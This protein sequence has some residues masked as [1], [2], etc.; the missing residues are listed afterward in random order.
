MNPGNPAS[1]TYSLYRP[2]WSVKVFNLQEN[3]AEAALKKSGPIVDAF[4][5]E[6]SYMKGI[7]ITLQDEWPRYSRARPFMFR[8][9]TPGYQLP[10]SRAV[11]NEDTVRFYQRG[12]GTD[13]PLIQFLSFY[14]VLEYHFLRVT[15]ELLYAK[16]TRRMNDPRF[17]ATSSSLDRIIQ[18]VV[19]HKRGTDE[20]E[21]LK[22]VLTKYVDE[23][24]LME[25]LRSYEVYLVKPF[26]SKKR[27]L[28]A[29]GSLILG[30]VFKN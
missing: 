2:L 5:F 23:N 11:F 3:S 6:L 29:H 9:P 8:S 7:T 16:L 14:Q 12:M 17:S 18:D 4:L 20:I 28:Y 24:E 22:A 10:F 21:M 30:A 27:S 1:L 15:D 25:F 26:Y 13:D 19:D